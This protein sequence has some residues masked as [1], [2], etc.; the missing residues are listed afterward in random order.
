M[1]VDNY[2]KWYLGDSCL[3]ANHT[4]SPHYIWLW[5]S[6]QKKNEYGY[7]EQNRI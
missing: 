3:I 4:T 7:S 2:V 6:L 1:L 5:F